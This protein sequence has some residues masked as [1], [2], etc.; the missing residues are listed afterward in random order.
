MILGILCAIAGVVA[1]GYTL[2]GIENLKFFKENM[3]GGIVGVL[4]PGVLSAS[5]FYMS[6]DLI[7]NRPQKDKT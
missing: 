6:F 1:L 5:A 2:D 3:L 4:V 7:R